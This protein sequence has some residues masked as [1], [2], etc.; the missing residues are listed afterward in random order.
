MLFFEYGILSIYHTVNI[1]KT[2]N[3]QCLIFILFKGDNDIASKNL[4]NYS[5][6]LN[7]E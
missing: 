4:F 3:M 1:P 5:G 2:K 7:S 6:A